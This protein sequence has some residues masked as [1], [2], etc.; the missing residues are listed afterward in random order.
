MDET[1]VCDTTCGRYRARARVRR[2]AWLCLLGLTTASASGSTI[3]SYAHHAPRRGQSTAEY[4]QE[5]LQNHWRHIDIPASARH[6]KADANGLLPQTSFVA[7]LEWRHSLNP[8]RFDRFHPNIG[9]M[10]ERDIIIRTALNTPPIIGPSITPLT[11]PQTLEHPPHYPS[12]PEPSTAVIALVMIGSAAFA[13]RW[14]RAHRRD[15]IPG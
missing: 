1:R 7:Y 3:K 2:W 11:G 8:V 14:S 10:I 13:R 15:R 4:F 6:L 12:V 9:P 5:A